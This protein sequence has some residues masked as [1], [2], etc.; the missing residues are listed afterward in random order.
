MLGWL[1][2]AS[3]YWDA[4]QRQYQYVEIIVYKHVTILDIYASVNICKHFL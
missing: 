1:E 4:M 3:Q 2:Q